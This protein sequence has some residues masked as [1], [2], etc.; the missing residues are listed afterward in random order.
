MVLTHFTVTSGNDTAGRDPRVW[1]IQ[2]S[3]DGT[4]WDT[5]F[6][7]DDPNAS[8][9][10]ARNQVIL[11]D[12][13]N[14]AGQGFQGDFTLPAAYSQFRFITFQ[15]GLTSGAFFQ[16]NEVE[17]FGVPEPSTFVLAGLGLLGCVRRR[18]RSRA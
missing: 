16:I 3:L 7:Q 11:F 6:R 5:I 8:I 15:T 14:Y 18:R 10:S 9:W 13:A 1:E 12:V 2:G 17:F 4:I